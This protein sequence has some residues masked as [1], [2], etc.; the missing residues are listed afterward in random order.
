[1]SLNA[2][3]SPILEP[4]E[5]QYSSQ[6]A[7]F[8]KLAKLFDS[9]FGI[10]GTNIRFGWDAIIGLIPGIGDT[11]TL[12]PQAYF[13]IEA[14]RLK[15]D[16]ATISKMVLNIVIDWVAGS[17]PLLGDIFDVAFKSNV[18]NAKLLADVLRKKQAIDI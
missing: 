16:S 3:K 5:D 14:F 4:Y 11:L 17:I 12:I 13:L 6:I 15:A 2:E 10:P 9:Q 18:L 7:R 8:E 1:M